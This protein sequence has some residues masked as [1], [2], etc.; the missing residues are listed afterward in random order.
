MP[1]QKVFSLAVEVNKSWKLLCQTEQYVKNMNQ[2]NRKN[3]KKIDSLGSF[4]DIPAAFLYEL[5]FNKRIT[6][7]IAQKTSES[8]KQLQDLNSKAQPIIEESAHTSVLPELGIFA[9]EFNLQKDTAETSDENEFQVTS[10]AKVKQI[11]QNILFSPEDLVQNP[12]AVD[13]RFRGKWNRGRVQVQF[14]K[15]KR[16]PRQIYHRS[17]KALNRQKNDQSHLQD[18]GKF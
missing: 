12:F 9:E 5:R 6:E 18:L 2:G 10:E 17:S 7:T 11:L 14:Q 3:H 8:N 4:E 13:M 16:K 15:G 1:E